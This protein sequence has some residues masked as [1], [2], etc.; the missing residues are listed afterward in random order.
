[1]SLLPLTFELVNLENHRVRPEDRGDPPTYEI[2]LYGRAPNPDGRS[3]CVIVED[4]LPYFYMLHP[5]D[6]RV[7]ELRDT[8]NCMLRDEYTELVY[9]ERQPLQRYR[10]RYRRDSRYVARVDCL[11]AIDM[12]GYNDADRYI[13]IHMYAP[14]DITMLRDLFVSREITTYESSVTPTMR[15]M[16]DKELVGCGRINICGGQLDPTRLGASTDPTNIST[17]LVFRCRMSEIA[18]VKDP[19]VDAA[20]LRV[21]A[22]DIEVSS[23]VIRG[24]EPR[25]SRPTD[26]GRRRPTGDGCCGYR[27]TELL[28]S[29]HETPHRSRAVPASSPSRSATPSS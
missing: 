27:T 20:P 25:N 15:F 9:G 2:R 23:S 29:S 21:L 8:L 16:I 14:A 6:G 28:K 19:P 26:P 5:G 10:G 13:R 7:G 11:T 22:Y 17:D 4:F 3:V 24:A 1:M 12:Y 18:A